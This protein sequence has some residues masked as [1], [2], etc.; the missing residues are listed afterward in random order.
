MEDG[1]MKVRCDNCKAQYNIDEAKISTT[2]L[3]VKCAKCHHVFVARLPEKH[4]AEDQAKPVQHTPPTSAAPT[5]HSAP[6]V[7]EEP[8]PYWILR[9]TD[10][11]TYS[12]RELS[13]LQRWIVEHKAM[14]N[15]E[16][17][18]DGANWRKLKDV[19]ELKSFFNIVDRAL[20]SPAQEQKVPETTIAQPQAR[21]EQAHA[22]QS[23][24]S[25]RTTMQMFAV[26]ESALK[27]APSD[28]SQPA[29]PVSQEVTPEQRPSPQPTMPE[30]VEAPLPEESKSA[31]E[32]QAIETAAPE[33]G[34]IPEQEAPVEKEPAVETPK[35]EEQE[36]AVSPEPDTAVVEETP[37][38]EEKQPETA[39]KEE[40]RSPDLGDDRVEMGKP[41][42]V[43][44]SGPSEIWESRREPSSSEWGDY[45]EYA[46][47]D[48][49]F[50]VKG[51]LKKK[52]AILAGILV[53]GFIALIVIMPDVREKV[54][55]SISGGLSESAVNHLNDAKISLNLYTL[56]SL[57]EAEMKL[58]KLIEEYPK[59]PEP[60][61]LL[62]EVN[63]T[64]ADLL[65]YDITHTEKERDK[66]SGDFKALAKRFE[67]EGKSS[68]KHP[69]AKQVEEANKKLAEVIKKDTELKSNFS[70]NIKQALEFASQAYELDPEKLETNRALADYYRLGMKGS[71]ANEHLEKALSKNAEDSATLYVKG[72]LFAT[73]EALVANAMESLKIAAMKDPTLIKAKFAIVHL[74]LKEKKVEEAKKTLKEIL[75]QN[76][77]HS[78]SIKLLELLLSQEKSDV[79]KVKGDDKQK[80]GKV[81][82]G[83]TSSTGGSSG[84]D[85]FSD[86]MRQAKTL[87]ERDENKEALKYFQKAARIKGKPEVYSGMGYC[88]FDLGNFQGALDTFK[89]ALSRSS[90]HKK[91]LIGLAMTYDELGNKPEALKYYTKYLEHYPSGGDA[92][93][94]Q[95][96]VERLSK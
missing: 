79:V 73:D 6:P 25:P 28:Q 23:P 75:R 59:L 46:D 91:A 70:S 35:H 7:H 4:E 39:V 5:T 88:Y 76:P 74:Y 69:L 11:K 12:F 62:A 14:E 31:T 85:S 19:E 40:D 3:A 72:A 96:A 45:D 18:N 10:G 89:K 56:E 67:T 68:P 15:D 81:S 82:K 90:R 20:K 71:K 43:E 41:A 94:A 53:V 84:G 32:E 33:A 63:T 30:Q 87:R 24:G 22:E 37:A 51:R 8:T 34:A 36:E 48:S 60:M 77:R 16:I 52:M 42:K 66:M 27:P 38:E 17:S 2:G 92:L 55:A 64:R 78:P 57:S 83:K 86:L 95:N 54:F 29:E 93:V 13:T 21:Q 1:E 58:K 9:R 44:E 50:A 65:S 47:D 49:E 26:P 61:A 80:K